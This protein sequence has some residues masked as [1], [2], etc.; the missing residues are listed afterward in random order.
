[1]AQRLTYRRRLS[2]NTR[3]NKVKVVKTPGKCFFSLALPFGPAIH[4]LLSTW[5]SW[6]FWICFILSF[7]RW[8]IDLYPFEKASLCS[9]M[10]WL[11][12]CSSRSKLNRTLWKP[13]FFGRFTPLSFDHALM[14]GCLSTVFSCPL[15]VLVN[16]LP[17]PSAKRPCNAL[18]VVQDALLVFALGKVDKQ[19]DRHARRGEERKERRGARFSYGSVLLTRCHISLSTVPWRLHF[20]CLS[21]EFFVPF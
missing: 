17:F 5:L 1:M 19:T 16:C 6:L 4:A 15:F 2:Y 21:L 3:S 11:W 14:Y 13:C 9:Q 8:K 18:M 7:V 20:Y 12:Q 10:W